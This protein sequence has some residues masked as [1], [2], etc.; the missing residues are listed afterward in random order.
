MEINKAMGMKVMPIKTPKPKMPK[1]PITSKNM[2]AKPKV[3][4]PAVVGKRWSDEKK[5]RT[6]KKAQ[7]YLSGGS[8]ALGIGALGALALKKGDL[9]N[10]IGVT[11]LGLGGASSFN[12]A[13]IQNKEAKMKPPKPKQ[14]V[15][16][17]RNK[18]QIKDIKSGLEPVRKGLGMDFGLDDV[19]QGEHL[20]VIAK[21]AEVAKATWVPKVNRMG[22]VPGYMSSSSSPRTV[23][24]VHRSGVEN[25]LYK[26]NPKTTVKVKNPRTGKTKSASKGGGGELTEAGS[27]L[28][29]AAVTGA[30]LGGGYTAAD[31]LINKGFRIH[32]PLSLKP[33]KKDAKHARTLI[34]NVNRQQQRT[35]INDIEAEAAYAKGNAAKGKK[36]AERSYRSHNAA[37]RSGGDA[38]A[39][40]NSLE[41]RGR[42]LRNAGLATG[43]VGGSAVTA[44]GYEYKKRKSNINKGWSEDH[45][46]AKIQAFDVI[47]PT[48]SGTRR[49]D[50]SNIESHYKGKSLILRRPKYQVVGSPDPKTKLKSGDYV[51]MTP[52]V[53]MR[54]DAARTVHDAHKNKRKKIRL[55]DSTYTHVAK[56][57][58][59][60]EKRKK[61]MEHT[62]TAMSAAG[63][64]AL[65]GGAYYGNKSRGTRPY[66]YVPKGK[67]K[68]VKNPGTGLRSTDTGT[69][70]SLRQG[71]PS[72]VQPKGFKGGLRTAGKG[73]A[74]GATGFALI[75]GSE[76]LKD[77]QR[78]RGAS[79]RP[80]HRSS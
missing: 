24:A 55:G 59:P 8:G 56:A 9:A 50:A 3:P 54:G 41:R 12:F 36:F 16:V 1:P 4:K 52:N 14:N 60:E 20:D 23:T 73:A 70:G 10:K 6:Q 66:E 33:L 21:R 5:L 74:L 19:H 80:L 11:S 13:S 79:Y 34:S 18:R 63:G 72:S 76:K 37:Y 29:G 47:R 25:P 31:K 57:Y 64:T 7:A 17:V 48:A 62:A 65:A 77:Y 30:V 43:T 28:A 67:R 38:Y 32:N 22:S 26:L 51:N 68:A 75:A 39:R 35:R 44:G 53:R 58:N 69:F 71:R 46:K 27:L 40:V 45:P 61:R 15:Y 2:V 78:G 42:N 49:F